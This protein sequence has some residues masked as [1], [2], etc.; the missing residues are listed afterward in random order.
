MDLDRDLPLIIVFAVLF[1]AS[2]VLAAAEAALLRVSRAAVAVQTEQGDRR[3]NRLLA[4]LDD[5]PKI[6]NSILLA[7]L[8][9]QLGAATVTG[10]LADRWFGGLGITLATLVLTVVLFVY[11]EAIP[12]TYAVRQPLRVAR[13]LS[14]PIAVV[15]RGL[16]PVVSLLVGF[17]DL[18]SP[19]KGITITTAVSEEELRQLVAD[20]AQAGEIEG[21]DQELIERSFHLGD[22][23]VLDIC[24][25]RLDIV[26]VP[27]ST[28]AAVAL[29]L[30]IASGHRR[31]PVYASTL[32][33]VIGVVR[34][35]D[36]AATAPGTDPPVSELVQE[37][38]VV[39]E[40]LRVMD[41][42][43]RFR[44]AARFVAVV[45]DEHGATTGLV[46]IEDVVS[47]LVGEIDEGGDT[48][49]AIT[50]LGPGRWSVPA[51]TPVAELERV[52]GRPLPRG[53]WQTVGGLVLDRA[54]RIPE[55]GDE[56]SVDDVGFR[57]TRRA[58]QRVVEV[59]VSLLA[60][61]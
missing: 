60:P 1:A 26:A 4:Q 57:V 35:R 16:R 18:Q 25:P 46:T 24:V 12:K 3:A 40:T 42:L 22:L 10:V 2:V 13:A 34:L 33:H 53:A 27:E 61:G 20:A 39:P 37:V 8:L 15:E 58:R 50:E 11:S 21:S 23:R 52:V 38:V 29:D 32:D 9:V 31:L 48:G 14:G 55:V 41:L 59:E 17:A 6:V 45:V 49:P 51:R 5:L 54:G 7:V 47:E 30:A 36:L 56:I 43:E 28:S 44:Q 19:G